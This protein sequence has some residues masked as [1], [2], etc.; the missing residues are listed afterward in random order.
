MWEDGVPTITSEDQ[1]ALEGKIRDLYKDF[2]ENGIAEDDERLVLA[3]S[4]HAEYL[5][6]GLGQLPAG[7]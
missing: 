2:V 5:C 1:R 6:G 7:L 4:D 3:R